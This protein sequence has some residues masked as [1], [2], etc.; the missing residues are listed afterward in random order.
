MDTPLHTAAQVCKVLTFPLSSDVSLDPMHRELLFFS[1]YAGAATK[2]LD[3]SQKN[4]V[5]KFDSY[6]L[7]LEHKLTH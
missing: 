3:F 6:E 5:E 7:L 4:V 2:F 1:S